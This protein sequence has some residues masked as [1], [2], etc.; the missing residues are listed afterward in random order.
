MKKT[1]SKRIISILLCVVMVTAVSSTAMAQRGSLRQDLPQLGAAEFNA[2]RIRNIPFF[3]AEVK[4]PNESNLEAITDIISSVYTSQTR[5]SKLFN[6]S[7]ISSESLQVLKQAGVRQL[8]DTEVLNLA[9]DPLRAHA[10]ARLHQLLDD[11]SLTINFVTFFAPKSTLNA[12]A[13][14]VGKYG[15]F[16]ARHGGFEFRFHDLVVFNITTRRFTHTNHTMNWSQLFSAS[17][18]LLLDVIGGPIASIVSALGHLSNF[19]D[20]VN[21]PFDITITNAHH[22]TRLEHYV[23]GN[24]VDRL[25]LIEDRS[26]RDP[27]NAFVGSASLEKFKGGSHLRL[28]HPILIGTAPGTQVRHVDS[29]YTE[30]RTPSWHGSTALFDTLISRYNSPWWHH[31]YAERLNLDA[32]V[33]RLIR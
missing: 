20:M 2:A 22:G 14:N 26:N 19:T 32:L 7:D 5:D 1:M 25:I 15:R 17:A 10:I 21:I 33:L 12:D 24:L 11:G 27:V 23:S 16:F 6:A 13:A 8:S 9:Y 29:P 28:T 4:E 30:I 31:L 3:V 18:F